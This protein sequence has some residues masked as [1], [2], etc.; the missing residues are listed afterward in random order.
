MKAAFIG[1]GRMGTAMADRI[2]AAGHDLAVYNRDPRKA[3]DLVARGA[4]RVGSISDAARHGAVV[5]TMLGN[6]AALSAVTLGEEGLLRSM[7]Q[8]SIHVVM[9]THSISLIKALTTAHSDAGQIL[10]GAP[11]MGR[12]PVAAAGQLG[13]LAGGPPAAV[14]ACAPLFTAMGRRTFDAGAEPMA[15]AAAKVANN[16]VLA[17][18]IEAM[19]EGFALAEK[20]GVSGAAFL[21]ILTD[22]VFAAP[23][24]KTYGKIIADKAY[25]GDA[26]FTAATGLKDI[27]LALSAGEAVGVPMPAL[28]ASRDRLLSAIAQ[29]HGDRDWTVM[30]LEQMR[31][32]GIG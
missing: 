18:A 23:A 30:A 21:D 24:Y 16:L 9:G 20:C 19:A 32:S 2:L 22:G 12:P 25:F 3:D 14:E 15:A 10:V 1:L 4:K 29:G 27:N 7:H 5:I 11:V 31:A 28:N 13:I 8:G 26:G 17:C 6:D